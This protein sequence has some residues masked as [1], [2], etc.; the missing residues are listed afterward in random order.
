MAETVDRLSGNEITIAVTVYERQ[1]YIRDA[2]RSALAQSCNGQSPRVIVVEDCGPDP[3]LQQ[4][5]VKE[6]GDRIQYFRNP[7]R[8]G[9]FDN[10][11]A[12]LDACRTQWLCILHDDDFL[13]PTFVK[14]MIELA[15]A[16]PGRAL[17]YGLADV[18]DS[19]G[20]PRETRQRSTSFAWHELTLEEWARYDPVCFPAQLFKVEA[21]RAMG[22]FRGSSHYT[23]DWEMWFKLALNYGAVATNRV[24]A[25]YREYLSAGRGTSNVD[26][27]GTKYACTNMQR[28]RNMAWLRQKNPSAIRFDR[29]ALF[30]ESP[31]SSRFILQYG[32]AF[33]PR[34]LRYNAGLFLISTAP[35]I[36]YRLLQLITQLF[37]WRILRFASSVC[38][39][40]QRMPRSR[41]KS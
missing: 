18:V 35:H 8:R 6:F 20:K 26:I 21:A 4:S 17:Y 10:W 27:S 28:K 1:N 41:L 14:S 15:N 30:K 19:A 25:N 5:A 12:C 3:T 37:S 38:N 36:G 39:L 22:G 24:V 2:I 13:E 16:A 29:R 34:M 9:L 11:N 7:R 32:R 33:S 31:M 23:A 40:F